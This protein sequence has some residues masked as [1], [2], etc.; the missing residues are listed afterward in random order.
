MQ[1]HGIFLIILV[2]TAPA[3][4]SKSGILPE[5]DFRKILKH[6]AAAINSQYAR[7]GVK[8]D[9]PVLCRRVRLQLCPEYRQSQMDPDYLFSQHQAAEPA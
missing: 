5:V 1:L 3:L 8:T 2:K 9:H 6:P 4:Q 7:C